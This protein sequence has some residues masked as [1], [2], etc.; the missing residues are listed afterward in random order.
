MNALKYLII[1]HNNHKELLALTDHNSTLYP[2]LRA[3][4]VHHVNMEEA[5]FYPNLLRLEVL[6]KTVREAWEEHNLIMQLLQEMD[7]LEVSSKEFKAKF[8]VLKKLLLLHIEEEEKKL[9]PG[10][11][12]LASEEFLE[13]VG[14]QMQ[15]QKES[16]EPLEVLYPEKEGIHKL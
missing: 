3:E 4:I 6:E 7:L 9:F 8:Q 13:D 10:I 15:I 16:V 14:E 12:K 11:E 2:K 5:V 1:D